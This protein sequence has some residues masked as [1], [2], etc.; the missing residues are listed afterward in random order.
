V[1]AFL[2]RSGRGVLF[3]DELGQAAPAVQ[4]ACLQLT[5]DR[6]IG[7]YELPPGWA[8]VAAANRAEDRAGG[9]RLISPLL[10]RFIHL[11]LDVDPEDWQ[12]WAV[13]AGI[14]PEIRS[15]LRFR[16]GLLFQFDPAT[17]PRAFAT[18]RS[19]AF[20]SDVLAA[21]SPDRSAEVVAGCVG[22]GAAAEFAAFVRLARELPNLDV[23]LD[24]PDAA[25]IPTEPGVMYALVGAVVERVR[26]QAA[27]SEAAVRYASRLPEEFGL[28]LLRDLIAIHPKL[29][30]LPVVQ[31]WIAK[32]RGR[33]LFLAA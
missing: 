13:T 10:N 20:V 12:A 11:D 21:P 23:V 8:V 28:L 17:N 32:A 1:P 22:E 2:P 27:L 30:S 3:L 5:L 25:P 15:F 33:G 18:P 9:H 24:T 16:P 19:W 29:V 4:A 6:R 7:E 14:A 26:A 31:A